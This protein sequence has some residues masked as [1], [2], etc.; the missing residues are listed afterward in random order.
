MKELLNDMQIKEWMERIHQL[1][2]AGI[3]SNEELKSRYALSDSFHLKMKKM[4]EKVNKRERKSQFLKVISM[5]AAAILLVFTILNS[6]TVV[7]AAKSI[8]KWFDT[9]V[10]FKFVEDAEEMRIPQYTLNY[11]PEGYAEVMN[12]YYD[13]T[14]GMIVYEHEDKSPLTLEYGISDGG[15]NVDNEGVELN[16]IQE[17]GLTIYFFEAV[18]QEESIVTWLSED[19]TTVFTLVGGESKEEFLRIIKNIGK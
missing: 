12:E 2:L 1:E 17:N 9:Y 10:S 16:I 15:I 7:N 11:V 8:I 4:I 3:P 13:G 18:S 5:T 6:K 14:A 19:E